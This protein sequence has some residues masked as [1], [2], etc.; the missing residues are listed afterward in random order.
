M[1]VT[2]DEAEACTRVF[3]AVDR[4]VDLARKL[5]LTPAAI[6][7][8]KRRGKCTLDLVLAAAE[9]TGRSVE[10]FLFG[11]RPQG[12]AALRERAKGFAGSVKDA[13]KKSNAAARKLRDRR[14]GPKSGDE[15]T[16]MMLQLFDERLT[17]LEEWVRALEMQLTA[18]EDI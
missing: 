7:N 10:W 2:F 16:R 6:S 11:D 15:Q 4:Q 18:M 13:R 8:L 12:L 1:S 5:E 9:L 17:G 14:T 3:S